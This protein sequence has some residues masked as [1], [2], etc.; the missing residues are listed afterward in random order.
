MGRALL[1]QEP[2]ER[3]HLG[4]LIAMRQYLRNKLDAR[5]IK[6]YKVVCDPNCSS[7]EHVRV[8]LVVASIGGGLCGGTRLQH[9]ARRVSE[10]ERYFDIRLTWDE[11]RMREPKGDSTLLWVDRGY[12]R[13][14]P[15]RIQ[16]TIRLAM[17]QH[18]EQ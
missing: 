12:G 9:V 2:H 11:R 1:S 13:K 14:H 5:Q 18:L 4:K 3:Q 6:E 7:I 16:E 15:G 10:W 17:K 8:A